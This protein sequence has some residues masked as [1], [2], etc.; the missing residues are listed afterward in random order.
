[1]GV[2]CEVGI[3]DAGGTV[4][5]PAAGAAAVTAMIGVVPAVCDAA[6][7]GADVEASTVVGGEAGAEV[8]TG[9]ATSDEGPRLGRSWNSCSLLLLSGDSCGL[10]CL[11]GGSRSGLL[12]LKE[13]LL[14]LLYCE[15]EHSH[16]AAKVALSAG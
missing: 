8:V 2:D 1:M 12:L 9:G 14:P 15:L 5:A 13:K 16:G 6:V 3:A 10:L 7:P 4:A 11:K